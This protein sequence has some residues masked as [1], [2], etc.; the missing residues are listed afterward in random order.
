MRGSTAD[1][2]GL[3]D[4]SLC[5]L[6]GNDISR[7]AVLSG[8]AVLFWRDLSAGFD[9][10][11]RQV[12]FLDEFLGGEHTAN[13]GPDNADISL[14]VSHLLQLDVCGIVQDCLAFGNRESVRTQ[15]RPADFL[16]VVVELDQAKYNVSILAEKPSANGVAWLPLGYELA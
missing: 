6:I 7:K 12:A 10:Q 16:V 3:H 1:T 13:A 2:H 8:A 4:H 5:G 9:Q 11:Y 14:K 15:L